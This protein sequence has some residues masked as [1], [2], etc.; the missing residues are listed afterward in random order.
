M[1]REGFDLTAYWS[2]TM[3]QADERDERAWLAATPLERHN[4][5]WVLNSGAKLL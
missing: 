2:G 3:E 4:S 1:K 5:A